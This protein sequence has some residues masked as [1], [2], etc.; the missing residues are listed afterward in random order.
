[1][2]ICFRGCA[3]RAIIGAAAFGSGFASSFVSAFATSL[4]GVGTGVA[5]AFFAF[6]EFGCFAELLGAAAAEADITITRERIVLASFIG[7]PNVGLR[8]TGDA[9]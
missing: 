2:A 7:P 1:V 3:R 6:A 8:K 5:S 4:F 9:A